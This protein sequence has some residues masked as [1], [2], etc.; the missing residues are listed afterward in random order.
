MTLEQAL[1]VEEVRQRIDE[2]VQCLQQAT[3]KFLHAI[4]AAAH[5]IPYGMRYMAS[6]LRAALHEKFP[7]AQ[8]K[9]V[10]KVCWQ[11]LSGT[12]L[13]CMYYFRVYNTGN[14]RICEEL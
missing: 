13:P 5:N 14:S 4:L 7:E 11:L 10:L 9:D 8:E 3:D 6:V 12:R 1:A 2:S